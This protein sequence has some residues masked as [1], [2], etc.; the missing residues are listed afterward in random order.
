ME[1]KL[2]IL[3]LQIGL[4]GCEIGRKCERESGGGIKEELL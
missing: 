3:F 2:A 1:E 4:H